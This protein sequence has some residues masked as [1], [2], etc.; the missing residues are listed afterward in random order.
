MVSF[1]DLQEDR[2]KHA[3][4]QAAPPVLDLQREVERLRMEV[5]MAQ[6]GYMIGEEGEEEEPEALSP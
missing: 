2:Q 3:A 1:Q 6:K 5:E 4:A